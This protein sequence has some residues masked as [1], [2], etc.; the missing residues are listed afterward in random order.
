MGYSPRGRKE[1]DMTEMTEHA[2][3]L[4]IKHFAQGNQVVNKA[5]SLEL[6]EQGMDMC[7]VA[8]VTD[9]EAVTGR[10]SVAH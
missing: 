10:S 7:Q 4:C 1:L 6:P 5:K 9:A 2:C 8:D 3:I